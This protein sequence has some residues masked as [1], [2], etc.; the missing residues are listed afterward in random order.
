MVKKKLRLL[1]Q[2]QHHYGIAKEYRKWDWWRWRMTASNRCGVGKLWLELV[3]LW[4]PEAS[5]SHLSNGSTIR[6]AQTM[7]LSTAALIF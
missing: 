2:K 3:W 4:L 1:D 5:A 6:K 7:T